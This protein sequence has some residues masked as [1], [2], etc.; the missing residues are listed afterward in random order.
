MDFSH[1]Y[2]IPIAGGKQ[3]AIVPR[4]GGSLEECLHYLECC[5]Q[6]VLYHSKLLLLLLLGGDNTINVLSCDDASE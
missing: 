5:S 3:A 2:V 6:L 4:L 1:Y